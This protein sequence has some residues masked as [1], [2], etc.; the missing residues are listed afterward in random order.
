MVIGTGTQTVS[1]FDYFA[2]ETNGP[3]FPYTLTLPA[4]TGS[5]TTMDSFGADGQAG[6]S[7]TANNST[8]KETMFVNAVQ[9]SGSG[10]AYDT[11]SDWNGNSGDPLPQLWDDTGHTISPAAPAGTSI[12][13]VVI[14]NPND[15]LIPVG[16]VVGTR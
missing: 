2:W 8:S 11:D 5:V 13:K 14:N 3:S 7:R 6:S 9:I 12:L 16:N 15:C 4:P 1:V 10:S